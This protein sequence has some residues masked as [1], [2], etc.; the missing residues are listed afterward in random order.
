MSGTN[1]SDATFSY[2]VNTP[3]RTFNSNFTPHATKGVWVSYTVEISCV[4]TLSGGQSGT[5][6]LRSDTNATPTTVRAQA[7][8]ANSVSLAIALTAV[9][10]QRVQLSYFVPPGHNVRLVTSGSASIS[11]VNQTEITL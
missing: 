6:E 11:I 9:N 7:Y 1:G 2:T 10:T 5:V 8:N 3:S 4:A